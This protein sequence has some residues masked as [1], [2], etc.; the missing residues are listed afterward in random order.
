[1]Q[2]DILGTLENVNFNPQT[3]QEEVIQNVKTIIT[4]YK[5]SVPLDRNFG[6]TGDAIDAPFPV[7]MA[8][9]QSDIIDNILKYEPRAKVK[10]ITFNGDIDGNL[11]PNVRIEI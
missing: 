2:V 1:M 4:T 7:A 9:L 11:I 5:Y 3:T 6:I 8:K 10:S